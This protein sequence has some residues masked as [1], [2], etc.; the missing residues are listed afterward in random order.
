MAKVA[1]VYHSKYGHTK[2][3]AECISG[4]ASSIPGTEVT[5]LSVDELPGPNAD[6]SYPEVWEK[7]NQADAIIFGSAI[8]MGDISA[9]MKQ[10]MEDSS[11]LWGKQVWKDKLAAGFVNSG[12]MSGDKLHGLMSLIVFAGQHSMIWVSTGL[13]YDKAAGDPTGHNRLGFFLGVGTQSSHGQSPEQTPPEGDR[14]TAEHLGKR[15]AE[16]AKRWTGR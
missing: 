12:S 7:L 14:A 1:I 13:M 10:F 9:G 4:G 8:Y 15:V 6:R 11:G 2:A 16:A 3:I 5:M